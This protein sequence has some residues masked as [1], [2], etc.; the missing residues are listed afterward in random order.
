M[1]RYIPVS[2]NPRDREAVRRR[3]RD[4]LGT[5]STAAASRFL[6]FWQLQPLLK[7][8]E[9]RPLCWARREFFE[10]LADVPEPVLLGTQGGVAHFAVDV[11]S[12]NDPEVAFGLDEV[13]S[14]EDLR[15]NVGVMP[16]P[17]A[18]IAAQWRAYVDWH[19]R[20]R[21]CAVCG[22]T[23]R[24]VPGGGHRICAECQVEHFPR[25]DPVAI[26]AVVRGDR[27]LLG[28][29]PGWPQTMFSALAGF[30]EPGETLEEAV[31]REVLEESGI[32]VG[33]VRYVASQPWTFPSSLMIGCLAEAESVAISIDR[34]EIE[35]ARWFSRDV[36]RAALEGRTKEVMVPP[37][38]AIAHHL[39]RA[40]V[41][42]ADAG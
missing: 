20:H 31:R 30:V 15:A 1:T 6:P 35:E 3:D 29:G 40:W 7:R 42:E 22:G 10:D 14:F 28:R 41:D 2:G 37:P 21:H 32:A 19:A 33:A 34:A 27:C 17:D 36:L 9:E 5:L 18:A 11:T 13:A 16:A 25:T 12:A 4:W 26:A 8:G 39:I 23:T 24:S 38:M